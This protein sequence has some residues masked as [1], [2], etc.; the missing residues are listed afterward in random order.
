MKNLK[1]EIKWQMY[2]LNLELQLLYYRIGAFVFHTLYVV[3]DKIGYLLF[4]KER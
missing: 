3:T 2:N 1:E 4:G